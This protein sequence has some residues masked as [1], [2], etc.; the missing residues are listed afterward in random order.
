MTAKNELI[1]LLTNDENPEFIGFIKLEDGYKCVATISPPMLMDC[2]LE[3]VRKAFASLDRLANAEDA[4]DVYKTI[5]TRL[6]QAF[7]HELEKLVHP[8]TTIEV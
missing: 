6:R 5:H 3:A 1:D 7:V 8:A 4:N 2:A